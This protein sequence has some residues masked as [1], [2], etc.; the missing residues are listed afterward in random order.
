MIT[1]R[2]PTGVSITYNAAHY[3]EHPERYWKLYDKAPDKGGDLIAIIQAS[4]G[5]ILEFPAPCR[6]ENPDEEWEPMP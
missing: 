2:F 5:A 3:V 4:A 6:I 1:V